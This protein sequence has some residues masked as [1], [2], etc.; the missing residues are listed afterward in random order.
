MPIGD[1][2]WVDNHNYNGCFLGLGPSWRAA[3]TSGGETFLGRQVGITHPQGQMWPFNPDGNANQF[4][5]LTAPEQP[6]DMAT[7]LKVM[8]TGGVDQGPNHP[9]DVICHVLGLRD[10]DSTWP[11][12]K[13]VIDP[14]TGKVSVQND[15]V[16]GY[17]A[18]DAWTPG[19]GGYV[20]QCI[21]KWV[22]IFKQLPRPQICRM[23]HEFGNGTTYKLPSNPALYIKCWRK[24]AAYFRTKTPNLRFVWCPAAGAVQNGQDTQYFPGTYP[25]QPGGADWIGVDVYLAKGQNYPDWPLTLDPFY[26]NYSM[27]NGKLN[28]DHIPIMICESGTEPTD[29]NRIQHINNILTYLKTRYQTI[30][31]WVYWDAA[32]DDLSDVPAESQQAFRNWVQDPYMNPTVGT[33]PPPPPQAAESLSTWVS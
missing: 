8:K 30:K 24:V 12:A 15:P 9:Q 21:T 20:D 31:V 1:G 18:I 16:A 3:G 2:A 23:W 10:S 13:E 7:V 19:D 14:T 25:S 17:N 11:G 32:A 28:T 22:N 29:P 6:W 33:G 27:T 4:G 5:T 26:A